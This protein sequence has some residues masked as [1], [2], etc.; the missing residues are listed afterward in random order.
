MTSGEVHEFDG[1]PLER[2]EQR[3]AGETTR[4]RRR[5]SSGSGRGAVILVLL[6]EG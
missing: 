6:Q 5:R 2:L 4:T 3:D 1:I